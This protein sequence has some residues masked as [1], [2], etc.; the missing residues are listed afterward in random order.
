MLVFM[1]IIVAMILIAIYLPLVSALG[2]SQ[3]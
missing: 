1:G 2:Q 3:Y